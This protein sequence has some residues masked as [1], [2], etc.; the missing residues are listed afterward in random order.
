MRVIIKVGRSCNNDCSF[1]HA[2][3]R[4]RANEPASLITRKIERARDLGA[5]MIILS[6]G[7]PTLHSH[8]LAFAD[9][10]RSLGLQLGLI[11][12]GRRLA[13]PTLVLDLLRRNL[14]YVYVSLHGASPAIHD[15]VVRSKA[16]DDTWSAIRN[17]AGRV[18]SLTVN[19]VVTKHNLSDLRNVVDLTRDRHPLCMKFTFPQPKGAALEHFD[20]VVPTLQEASKA[21]MDAIA[22]G[23][24]DSPPLSSRFGLEGFPACLVPGFHHLRNDLQTHGISFLS[25][26]EDEDLVPV[27]TLLSTMTPRC[28]GCSLRPCCPGIFRGYLER[29]GDGE[30]APLHTCPSTPTPPVVSPTSLGEREQVAHERR[31]WV[32]LTYACN[33]RCRFCLDRETGRSD[34]RREDAIKAEIV[35]GRREGAER[36]I[37][38]GGEPTTHPRFPAFV[39]LGKRA[40]YRWVQTVSN[41]RMLSYPRFLA[42][43]IAA[44]LDEVTVSMHGHEASL[45]DELVGVEGAFDQ[46]ARGIRA[47]LASRRLVVN[48]DIVINAHNVDLLPEMLETFVQ[49]GVREFDLLQIIP[50]GAAW[51]PEHR[52]LFYDIDKHA[53]SIRRALA[54]S[55]R[56][57]LQLWLNRF[58]P[59]HAEGYEFL[60]QDPHKLHDEVRGRLQA[61]ETY[62]HGGPHLPCREP[63]RCGRCYLKGLCDTFE[64]MRAMAEAAHVERLRAHPSISALGA[65]PS[66]DVAEIVASCP[67]EAEV[68]ASSLRAQALRLRLD[69]LHDL[70]EVIGTEARLGGLAVQE[71][72][73]T[74]PAQLKE[75]LLCSSVDVVIELNRLTAPCLPSLAPHAQRLVLEQPSYE[76]LTDALELDVDLR[77]LIAGLGFAVRTRRIAPCL[78]GGVLTGWQDVLDTGVLRSDGTIDPQLL[79][80]HYVRESFHARSLRCGGCVWKE[81]CSGMHLNWLRAHGFGALDPSRFSGG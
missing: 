42:E 16:F 23:S 52:D 60:I 69:D 26:P 6:G 43:I 58:P 51:Q 1:C 47:A 24:A 81:S 31:H 57:G 63:S 72:V 65:I 70:S 4:R 14:R 18:D 19:T 67:K 36:L 62:V 37:L 5:S 17:L 28:E 77:A 50:F 66:A 7:E 9:Q 68:I 61:F 12:N 49:W 10:V 55:Q 78:S 29:R 79:T 22:Y 40:G 73:V 41:G 44:G 34:A 3:D 56:Q 11:T 80:A 33:N 64:K 71:V 35:Q 53:E 38:S 75:A 27:D 59:E 30:L 46:A 76:R 21:V 48:I 13:D 15:A 25:E 74:R 2:S 39:R 45:H 8:L 32:R 20:L 54:F